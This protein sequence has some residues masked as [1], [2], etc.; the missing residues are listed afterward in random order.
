[1]DRSVLAE[2]ITENEILYNEKKW[3][4]ST[5]TADLIQKMTH[6]TTKSKY[7]GFEY[8]EYNGVRLVDL[9]E[10]SNK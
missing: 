1:M 3:A 4:I 7:N 10:I 6:T 9:D 2:V 8:W 5:L